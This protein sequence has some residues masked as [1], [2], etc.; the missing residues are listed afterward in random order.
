MRPV[1]LSHAGLWCAAGSTPEAVRANLDRAPGGRLDLPQQAVPY[2]F[3]TDPG[4]PCR[5][6]LDEAL[7]AVAA[8]LGP[9]DPGTP[10]LIGSSS[11]LIG[12][13][14]EGPWPPPPGEPADALR[15]AVLADWGLG[16]RVFTSACASSVHALEAAFGLVASGRAAEAVVLGVELLNRATPAGFAALQLLS[17]TGARPLDA[18]RDGLVLGEAVAA[19]RVSA[20]PS[21]WRL[22]APALALDTTSAT[23]YAEDGATIAS[24]MRAALDL[25]GLAPSSVRAVK[26]QASGAPATDAVEARALRRVF[27]AAL[28]PLF[29]LKGAL[30]HTLGACGV[31]ELAATLQ[32]LEAGALPPTAGF[33]RPDPDLGLTPAQGPWDG[34]ACLFNIQ[35]FGGCL[36]AWVVTS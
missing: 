14:E 6:R 30:G 9:L 5:A 21:R 7:A 28:P 10:L 22:H 8:T 32:C 2:A 11:L 19:V 34:G 33:R 1:F 13:L 17:P 23:G 3:A 29:S 4:K 12:A 36:A 18:D 25:A 26:L 20:R 15:E 27:G 24:V 16:A 31:A 35:G